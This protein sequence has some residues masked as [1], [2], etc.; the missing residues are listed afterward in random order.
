MG[1]DL[2][3]DDYYAHFNFFYKLTS[4]GRI[5]TRNPLENQSME[6]HGGHTAYPGPQQGVSVVHPVLRPLEARE[7]VS[8]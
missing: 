2:T 8:K 6:R 3:I 1:L 4:R 5:G 7:Q